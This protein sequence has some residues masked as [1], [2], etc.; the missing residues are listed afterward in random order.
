MKYKWNCVWEELSPFQNTV[1]ILPAVSEASS[2]VTQTFRV[3]RNLSMYSQLTSSVPPKASLGIAW[4]HPGVFASFGNA[5]G[6]HRAYALRPIADPSPVTNY[7]PG[8][9][10]R[11]CC[12]GMVPRGVAAAGYYAPFH[13]V[14]KVSHD[15]PKHSLRI[16]ILQMTFIW[17]FRYTVH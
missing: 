12:R 3:T 7:E 5:R 15:E 8:E 9:H 4:H 2:V 6:M 1:V 13:G 16:P 10:G 14:C 11:H 17:I